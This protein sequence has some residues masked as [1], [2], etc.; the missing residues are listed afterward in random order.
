MKRIRSNKGKTIMSK[1]HSVEWF[2]IGVQGRR[3]SKSNRIPP[4]EFV[5]EVDKETGQPFLWYRVHD[6]AAEGRHE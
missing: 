6:A 5:R 3:K 4:G 1:D 2:T